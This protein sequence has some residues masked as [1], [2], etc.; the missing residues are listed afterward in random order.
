MT[1]G[2]SGGGERALKYRKRRPIPALIML[3]LLGLGAAIVWLQVIDKKQDNQAGVHCDP[4]PPATAES[5]KPPPPPAPALGQHLDQAG[6][7]QTGAASPD[8]SQIRVLN[9][10]GQRGEAAL[11]TESLRQL[12]FSQIGKPDD[13]N[14]YPQGTLA[15]RG[16][17]RFGPQGA[18]AARTLSLI[19]P[20]AELIKDNRQDATV[21]FVLGRKFDDIQV[22]PETRQALK[23]VLDWTAQHPAES[24]GLQAVQGQGAQIDPALLDAIRKPTC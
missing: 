4:P 5:G 18:A 1:A 24:G 22:R 15:C 11:I 6:L 17:I 16:Q 7:D 10:S 21:D 2:S 9:A 13:D 14:I 23:Q 3:V 8:Q 12:G 20:C 19:E